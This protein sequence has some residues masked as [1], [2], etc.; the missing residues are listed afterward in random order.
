MREQRTSA[1]E[2]GGEPQKP[3]SNEADTDG[4]SASGERLPARRGDSGR[5]LSGDEVERVIR[6]AS[7]LQFRAG[8]ADS[9]GL[10]EGELI[11]IGREVGLE[12]RYLRQALAEVHADSLVPAMPEESETAARLFGSAIVRAS[13][14]VPGEPAEVEA[15]IA[16]HLRDRE[17]LKQVRYR[18]GGRS[19]WEPAGG[20]IS[21][22]RRAMDVGGH[23]YTLAKAKAVAVDVE[24]V[25]SGWSLVT[26]TVDMR[27]QR[28]ETAGGWFFGMILSAIPVGILLVAPGGPELPLLLGP[29][30]AGGAALGTATFASNKHFRKQRARMELVV[31]G[32]LDRLERRESLDQPA[33]ESWADS[34][35]EKLLG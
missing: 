8:T 26:I 35:R 27:N 18:P 21:T 3:T 20:L 7:D 16:D 6:R 29:S 15:R 28:A 13:R 17:L 9:E 33:K 31:Q 23:G 10:E 30:L 5:T 11:K 4:D 22:M 19:L 24:P 12:A 14:V 1:G 25:E 34:L 32:L 2:E